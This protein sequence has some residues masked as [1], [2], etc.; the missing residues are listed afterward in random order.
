MGKLV[1]AVILYACWWIYA[2]VAFYNVERNVYRIKTLRNNIY[3]QYEIEH[4][5]E[6]HIDNE[7]EKISKGE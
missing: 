3:C 1:F 6:K 4:E 2:L 7:I 5:L